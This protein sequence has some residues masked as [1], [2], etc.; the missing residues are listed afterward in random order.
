M[1]VAISSNSQPLFLQ[2]L[3]RSS[4]PLSNCFFGLGLVAVPIE[5]IKR[6][7]RRV[8]RNMAARQIRRAKLAW[9]QVHQNTL[10]AGTRILSGI[11]VHASERVFENIL[12]SPRGPGRT[13]IAAIFEEFEFK[14]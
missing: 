14:L 5:R 12:R 10:T 11:V 1:L 4:E 13:S 9:H 6:F 8:K 7:P 2:T 3:N